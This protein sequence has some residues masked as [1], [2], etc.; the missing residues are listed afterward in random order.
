M[1]VGLEFVEFRVFL[2]L[3]LIFAAE[4]ESLDRVDV[5]LAQL[6]GEGN[7]RTVTFEDVLDRGVF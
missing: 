5:I 3:D 7:K 4:P 2:F 1:S 6:D